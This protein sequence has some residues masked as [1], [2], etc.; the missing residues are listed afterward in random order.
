MPLVH[1]FMVYAHTHT[2]THDPS[3]W[4]H[5]VPSGLSH[6]ELSILQTSVPL[7]PS[8]DVVIYLNFIHFALLDLIEV[9]PC[10]DSTD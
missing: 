4:N 2:H 1:L 9:Q 7:Q 6:I 3:N 8:L 5:L 10:S